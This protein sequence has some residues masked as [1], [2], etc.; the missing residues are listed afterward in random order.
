MPTGEIE[1][2]ASEIA[3]F[4]ESATPPFEPKDDTNASEELRLEY[5][6]L[7]LRRPS[8]QAN[9]LLRHVATLAAR[10]FFNEE[11][12]AEIE[13]PVLTRSTP[14]GARDFLVPSRVNKGRFYALPQSP[15]L[16]KQLLMISG[17]DRYV[18]FARCFRDEDLRANRQPEFTQIDVEMAFVEPDDIFD[19]I[20]RLM[21]GLYQIIGREA[22]PPFPVM[23]FREAMDRFGSDK[24]DLRFGVELTDLTELVAG[25]G[26]RI[27]AETAKAGGVVKGLPVP[28]GANLSRRQL[29]EAEE[30]VKTHGAKGLVWAKWGEDGFSGP[31]AKFLGEDT[32]A[33]LFAAGACEPG[34]ALLMVADRWNA[35]CSALG[36]LRL[37]LAGQMGIIDEEALKFL[38]VVD[39]PLFEED[40]EGAPS[41]MHHPF[42]APHPDDIDLL[43]SN[44]LAVRSRAYDLVLNG[45]E[46]GGGSIRIHN[47]EIQQRVFDTLGIG[48]EEAKAKFGFL[49][50]ALSYGAPPHG[51]IAL[52]WDRIVAM[53]AGEEAIR[54]VIAFPK[55]TSGLCLMTK[56]PAVVE[57]GQLKELGIKIA[58]DAE[59]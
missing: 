15:Q 45:E 21:V 14:E 17:F 37:H 35:A 42:T 24:P 20:E 49:L 50:D 41:P 4:N 57:P 10:N 32:C 31:G 40:E 12:F 56:A 19:V 26:F 1:I 22:V 25:S 55:T 36:A 44:P 2:T 33:A 23:T 38:W 48:P 5:R 43:A 34:S 16:F 54:S 27:F 8:L 52:G 11:G 39:F 51:G 30:V 18:Q 7:D 28:G 3:V 6:Y 59:E 29:D 53:L 13:T 47:R 46:I 9:L 58:A